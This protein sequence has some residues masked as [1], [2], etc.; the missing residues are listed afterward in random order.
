MLRRRRHPPPEEPGW[1]E[2]TITITTRVSRKRGVGGEE[3]RWNRRRKKTKKRGRSRRVRRG[4]QIPNLFN[5]LHQTLV[6]PSAAELSMLQ[7]I[8]VINEI[9]WSPQTLN[10][11][12][13]V[14]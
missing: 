12:K 4:L 14:S 3:E 2:P 7:D 11:A 10:T 8:I 1:F 5:I 6:H 13:N 9:F